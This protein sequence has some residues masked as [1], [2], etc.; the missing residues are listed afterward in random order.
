MNPLILKQ[1][2]LLTVR[3]I[4]SNRQAPTAV[5]S[6]YARIPKNCKF[7]LFQKYIYKHGN[8]EVILF[9]A[10]CKLQFWPR[11]ILTQ[12]FH[13]VQPF[14]LLLQLLPSHIQPLPF[15]SAAPS[16]YWNHASSLRCCSKASNLWVSSLQVSF[17]S[18]LFS[19]CACS[20]I[21]MNDVIPHEKILNPAWMM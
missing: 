15:V 2:S 21:H 18:L 5:D 11:F 16:S 10:Q 19:F 1:K 3:I 8:Y 7:Q 17:P 9:G 20:Q 12:Q 14:L 6:K 4:E 13:L